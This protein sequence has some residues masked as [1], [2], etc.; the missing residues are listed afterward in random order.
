[1]SSAYIIA[2]VHVTDATQYEEYKKF[3]SLAM[4]AH[5]A[6]VCVRGGAVEILEGDWHPERLVVLK[7]PSVEG[8]RAFYA[9]AEY[10]LARD[11]RVGAA[12]MSMVLVQGV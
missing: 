2:N 4:Q 8:A 12:V 5:G 11:A 7:F 3:S 1:M 10:R 9:S 6:E